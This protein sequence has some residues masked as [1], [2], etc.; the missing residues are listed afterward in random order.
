[1]STLTIN[2]LTTEKTDGTGVFDVLM[3]AV[4]N[5]LEQEF[6]SGRIKGAEYSAAY[7]GSLNLAMQ[8]GL[9]FTLQKDRQQLELELMQA[10]IELAQK[11][12]EKAQVELEILQ[13]TKLLKLPAEIAQ[14]QA[15][16][17]LI[18]QQRQNLIAEA[19]NIP[20]Q[21][22]VL[23]SQKGKID[24]DTLQTEAQTLLIDQNRL[25][26]VTEGAN[27]V[28]Q[29]DLLDVQK[30]KIIQET[31]NLAAE[32]LN[33]PKQGLVLDAQKDKIGQ[34]TIN[35]EAE[36]LNIP[37]QGK[38]LD[39]QECK[40][41]AEF[42]L[43][44]VQKTKTNE[45][46]ALLAQKVATER[47]QTQALGVDPDSVVGKQKNLYQAQTDGFARDAEQKA[48]KLLA[49]AWAVQRTTDDGLEVAGT[50]LENPNIERAINKLLAGVGA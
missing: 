41:K 13:E 25:N 30:L 46:I 47:A 28:K 40:L 45:E 50:G 43:L 22:A 42:D 14:L 11:Q 10:Q 1:M 16:T 8:S 7:I 37:K 19:L 26:A 23:D 12:V 17:E 5:H 33:I 6:L 20:K 44:V 39:A 31:E 15:Q 34:E 21:G 38:V 4:K 27:L 3:R 2:T 36:A 48:A 35:L 18:G 24:A 49:D 9:Q 29:G 32:E